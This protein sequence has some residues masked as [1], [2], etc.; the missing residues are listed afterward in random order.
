[1]KAFQ[2]PKFYTRSEHQVEEGADPDGLPICKAMY[3]VKH[4]AAKMV[5]QFQDP[6][7][8]R[9]TYNGCDELCE[10]LSATGIPVYARNYIEDQDVD[11]E[12]FNRVW[13]IIK[14]GNP[15]SSAYDVANG[16]HHMFYADNTVSRLAEFMQQQQP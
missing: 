11:K 13:S 3:R 16:E 2:V 4:T 5:Q 10:I 6:I 7:V 12:K 14:M 9:V 1:M 8:L 15:L